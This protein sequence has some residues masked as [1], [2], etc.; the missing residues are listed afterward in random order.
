MPGL[1]FKQEL[2]SVMHASH[3]VNEAMCLAS[4]AATCTTVSADV[5]C[6]VCACIEPSTEVL[7]WLVFS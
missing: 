3:A 4:Q 1:V 6:H 2:S 7:A 5:I